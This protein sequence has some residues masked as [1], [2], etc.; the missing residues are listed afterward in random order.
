MLSFLAL[1]KKSFYKIFC[2][3][4]FQSKFISLNKTRI[5]ENTISRFRVKANLLTDQFAN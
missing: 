5:Y 3:L 1:E 2:F 4:C